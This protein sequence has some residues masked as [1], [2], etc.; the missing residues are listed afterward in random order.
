M[1]FGIGG[2]LEKAEVA[3][4]RAVL[5]TANFVDGRVTAGDAVREVKRNL[6]A[7]DVEQERAGCRRSITDALAQA[8]GFALRV[9]PLRILPPMFNRYDAGME[10]GSH[11]DNAVMGSGAAVRADVSLTVFLSEPEEYDGGG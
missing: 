11:V 3:R 1:L 8:E 2:L 7:I 5:E 9:L 6:Q 4:I 10:Y